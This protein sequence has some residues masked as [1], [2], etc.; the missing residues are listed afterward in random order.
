[1][2]AFPGGA[3]ASAPIIVSRH[4][5]I[6]APALKEERGTGQQHRPGATARGRNRKYHRLITMRRRLSQRLAKAVVAGWIFR[7]EHRR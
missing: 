6:D 1:M 5:V 3:L 7:R 2:G 4:G